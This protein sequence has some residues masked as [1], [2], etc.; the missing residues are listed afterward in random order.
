MKYR[1]SLDLGVGSIGSAVVELDEQNK[2]KQ[3]IDAGVRIFEVSEGALDRRGKRTARKNLLRT[4]KRLELLAKKLYE[5]HLWVN[6]NPEG[7]PNLIAKSPYKIRY[8]A[9]YQRLDNPNYVGRAIL[10]LAKHRGA[11]FVSAAE[12]WQE[13][14]LDEGEKSKNKNTPYDMILSHMKVTNSTTI[15]EYFY[16]RLQNKETR[17]IRQKDYAL[18]S[19]IVD[20][21]IPRWLV[22]EEFNKIWDKQ[23]PYFRQMQKPGLK[24]EI[25]DILFYERPSAPYATGKCI[26]FQD[27]DRLAKA[28]PL[29]E[30]RRIYEEVNNIRISTNDMPQRRL[31]MEERD[32]VVEE[33]LM[34]GKNAGKQAIKKLLGFSAQTKISLTDDKVI[35]AYL[36]SKSDF[37]EIECFR[38]LSS[39]QL[40]QIIDFISNPINPDDK[41]GRLYNEDDLVTKLMGILK[42]DNENQIGKLLTKLPKGRTMLGK[43]ATNLILEELKKA[44]VSHREVTDKLKKNNPHFEAAEEIA[45]QMQGKYEELPY[46]GKVLPTDV[47]PLPP[48]V[49]KNNGSNLNENEIKY[50]KIANPAVHMILNQIRL[51]VNEIIK[52]YGRPYDIN[53]EVGRDVGLSTRRKSE[54]ENEQKRNAKYNEE[55]IKY[56]KEHNIFINNK[57]ILKYKLAKEQG[58][59]DAY[60]PTV[61]ISRDFTGFEIEHIIPQAKHGSDTYS[62]LC[63]VSRNDNLNK[64]NDFAYD[65]FAKKYQNQPEMIREILKNAHERMPK[66]AWRFEPGAKEKFEDGGD[67]DETNRY[68]TDTRYVAKMA[69]RYLRVI[70]DDDSNKNRVLAVKGAQTAELRKR[71]NLQGLEYDLM[72][73]DVPRY[74]D[75]KPYWVEQTTGIVVDGRE[76]PDIDGNWKFYDKENNPQWFAKPR[77]DHRHHAMD[78]I[79]IA[80]ISRSLV[81]KMANKLEISHNKTE[82]PLT[83]VESLGDFRRQVLQVLQNVK[84]SHKAEHSRAGQ[85]HEETGKAVLCQNPDDKNSLIT[86]YVRKIL[87]VVKSFNDLNKILIPDSIKNEWHPSIAENKAKQAKLIEDF[88]L[89]CNTAEQI[90]LAENEKAVTDGKKEIAIT[91]AR[92]LSKAFKIIQDKGLWKGDKFLC[93]ENSSA[94]VYIPKHKIAYKS[95][96]NHRIDFFEKDGKIGWEVIKQFD[97]NQADF[98]PQWQKDGGKIL[99]SLHK[100]DLIELDTPDEWKEYANKEK[101]LAK[102]KKFSVGKLTIDYIA[103]ARA[104]TKKKEEPPYLI[105]DSLS[106]KGLSFYLGHKARKVELTPFGK[107]KKKHKALWDGK[108]TAA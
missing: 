87:N 9:I 74:V 2:A 56:L 16:K 52:I 51:V 83:S 17:V 96:N 44:V 33:L 24:K 69:M 47:Q 6:E 42:V 75:C 30:M 78:A 40:E 76:K 105:V 27:E 62:N 25:Y 60:N 81:Q 48:L 59:R 100:G 68:L 64:S 8:D 102:I 50:G 106:E 84:V 14:P 107:M 12:D 45:C 13:E 20:Y 32:R 99:W 104:T 77:I 37:Q 61:E 36:Y 5:N 3:I 49:I 23:T 79:T 18:K 91:E 10:H 71:W 88:K 80:C 97:A 82:M 7:T 94:L 93:Y 57:N 66:K 29:S 72:G 46:Y 35:G 85:F 63:L 55:A 101:C 21:A 31:T 108:K 43:T 41:N 89:Y 95:G 26:Y 90:L 4:R 54:L 103:D 58:W 15:G 11:G 1:L 39:E 98:I 92:I 65:Y 53:I 34:N 67:E 86:V 73:V 22:K 19:N 38:S 28:H 70:V